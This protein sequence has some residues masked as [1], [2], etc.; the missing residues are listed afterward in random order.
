MQ[1]TGCLLKWNFGSCKLVLFC[2][3][4]KFSPGPPT[5]PACSFS[6][7]SP[8]HAH[9]H[10]PAAILKAEKHNY[11]CRFSC[12]KK[13]IFPPSPLGSHLFEKVPWI[14]PA[15]LQKSGIAAKERKRC[16]GRGGE[17]SLLYPFLFL[18][19]ARS[20]YLW[21]RRK[22]HLPEVSVKWEWSCLEL[23]EKLKSLQEWIKTREGK[24]LGKFPCCTSV[25]TTGTFL[26]RLTKWFPLLSP[27]AICKSFAYPP[28]PKNPNFFT[29]S[30]FRKLFTMEISHNMQSSFGIGAKEYTI[31]QELKI[32]NLRIRVQSLIRS[33]NLLWLK[34]LTGSHIYLFLMPTIE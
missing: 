20:H 24:K 15:V 12:F 8:L 3:L 7:I 16:Q 13:F 29:N 6:P 22:A 1:F 31:N 27:T 23:K 11:M 17:S 33:E 30:I 19:L 4:N 5:F 2:F 18:N 14:S 34:E 25:H 21:Q 26:L 32:F 28:S 9:F 10:S